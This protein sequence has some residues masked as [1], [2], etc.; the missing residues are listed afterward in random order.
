MR[1]LFIGFLMIIMGGIQL[2]CGPEEAPQEALVRPIK[3]LELGGK[4]ADQVLEFPGTVKAGLSAELGFEAAG[5]IIELPVTEGQAVEEGALLARLDPR[6][7]ASKLDAEIA[8]ERA[9]RA[10]YDRTLLLFKENVTSKQQ[11]EVRK[12]NF[13]VTKA[14]VER[15][16]KSM[17]DSNL[18]APF[19]G[20]VAKISVENFETV[21]A[22]QSILI[23]ENDKVF[24]VT[25]NIPEQDAARIPPGLSLEERTQQAK[26]E[27]TVS[28]LPGRRFKARLTEFA[29]TADPKTRT[30]AA[31]LAFDNPGDVSLA[32]GM[33]ANVRV[34]VSD[35]ALGETGL[36][37]PS[38]AVSS[39]PAGSAIVWIVDPESMIATARE[40]EVGMLSGDQIR[41]TRG[42]SGNE[43]IAAS[44]VNFLF[45]GMVVS[46]LS[47]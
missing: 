2:A 10:E 28:A 13:D 43:W 38:G 23:V 9:A 18:K 11:L 21:Q 25:A 46:R 44:G 37:V 47:E 34:R 24:E 39:N 1:A 4:A 5:K 26:P 22:K 12:R 31:T 16:R 17:E 30:F 27:I 40:V 33:T 35:K 15:A 3:I 42:L 45:D 41:V 32:S 8:K 19:K 7:F 36:F 29:R 20:V 6:D 14:N